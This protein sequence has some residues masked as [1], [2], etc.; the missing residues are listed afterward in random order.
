MNLNKLH[1]ALKTHV[2]Q[3]ASYQR[4]IWELFPTTKNVRYMLCIKCFVIIPMLIF[5]DFFFS[6]TRF[7][8]LNCEEMSFLK[9][10]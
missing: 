6:I 7:L 4:I 2:A 5:K 10:H 9:Y 8:Q 1:L 3:C